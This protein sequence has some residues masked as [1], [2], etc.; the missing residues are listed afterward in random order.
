MNIDKEEKEKNANIDSLSC[1]L[2]IYIIERNDSNISFDDLSLSL[3]S[4]EALSSHL[5]YSIIS[6]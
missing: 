1:S 4:L 2:V 6:G 5:H 3:F